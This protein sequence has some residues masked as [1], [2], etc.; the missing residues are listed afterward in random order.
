MLDTGHLPLNTKVDQQIFS[1][2]AAAAGVGWHT[3][4]KPR[5]VNFVQ[6]FA[7]AGGAGGGGGVAGAVNTAA[8]GGGGGSSAQANIIFPA[9]CLPDVLYISVGYGGAGG[10]GS[11]TIATVGSAGI[12]TYISIDPSV[13]ANN[14]LMIVNPG[15]AGGLAAGATPGTG[16]AGGTVSTI[17]NASLAG[18]GWANSFL[19]QTNNNAG[20]ITLVGSAGTA[21]VN[22]AAGTA[23][24][25]PVTGLM[26][27]GGTGGGSLSATAAGTGL[28]GGAITGAGAFPTL[29]GGIV[30]GT[31][32]GT[33]G[34]GSNGMRPIPNLNYFYGGTGGS[35]TGGAATAGSSGG[36][37]GAG[38]FGCGG[39]GGGGCI[40][41][42]GSTGGAGGKGG[43]G[44]V[45]ATAW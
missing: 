42:T 25:L 44:I 45:I 37:G 4:R 22:A 7:L 34:L 30:P 19:G 41:G 32:T 33:G 8:G 17:A 28:A 38:A 11:T 15:S 18:T 6:F 23:Q 14:L 1:A 9:W 24:T 5:G 2:N 26:V 43:D 27:T 31:T 21:A 20:N 16:G 40:T 36:R 39:G 29:I 10:T 3:W 12:A 35:S 13:T